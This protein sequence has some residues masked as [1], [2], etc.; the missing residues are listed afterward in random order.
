MKKKQN[1]KSSLPP[2]PA[3]AKKTRVSGIINFMTDDT[4]LRAHTKE[5]EQTKKEETKCIRNETKEI[6]GKKTHK[7]ANEN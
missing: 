3:P 6:I 5:N 4:I 2:A 1:K 7:K